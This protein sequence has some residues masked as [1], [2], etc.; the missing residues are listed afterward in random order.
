[1][2][3]NDLLERWFD[4]CNSFFQC[5]R[6]NS[7]TQWF[8]YAPYCLMHCQPHSQQSKCTH[9]IFDHLI[10]EWAWLFSVLFW[11]CARH[12]PGQI[13]NCSCLVLD[14]FQLNYYIRLKL[15][16][17]CWT[18]DY[19]KVTDGLNVY[20]SIRWLH[21]QKAFDIRIYVAENKCIIFSAS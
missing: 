15:C 19:L 5:V 8:E 4:I 7:H 3:V 10:L 14:L 21:N 13:L 17:R 12:R 11:T 1:M 9:S 2:L 18:I 16:M 6:E 20:N